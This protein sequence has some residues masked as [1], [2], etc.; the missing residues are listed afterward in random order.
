MKHVLTVA[1][2]ALLAG[3]VFAAAHADVPEEV[4]AQIEAKLAE[5][6]CQMDPDDIEVEE[7]GYDLDDVICISGNQFDIKLDKELNEVSR[8]AE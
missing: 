8:R 3:P 4:V 2:S 5:I 1:A 6:Q 7:D